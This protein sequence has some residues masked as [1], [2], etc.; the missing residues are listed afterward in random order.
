MLPPGEADTDIVGVTILA[1]LGPLGAPS[2]RT[3]LACMRID[4]AIR[5]GW[6]RHVLREVTIKV[7]FYSDTYDECV[8][9]EYWECFKQVSKWRGINFKGD[10]EGYLYGFQ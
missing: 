2:S 10:A 5:R 9:K 4:G 7:Y 8:A 3:K 1:G 6:C